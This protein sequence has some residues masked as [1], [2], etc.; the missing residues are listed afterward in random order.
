MIIGIG[1]LLM[2]G[3][4]T[5]ALIPNIPSDPKVFQKDMTRR[6]KNTAEQIRKDFK[7]TT[8]N[9]KVQVD[10]KVTRKRKG[11]SYTFAA[12]TDNEIYGYVN[13]GT[14]PHLITAKNAPFLVFSYPST[15]KTQPNVLKSGKG[16]RGNK[17]ASKKQVKHPGTKARNF[18]KIIAKRFRDRWVSE[19]N[20][21]LRMYMLKNTRPAG[22]P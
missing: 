20:E 5:K 7:K 13:D 21:A 10:F 1:G 11:G 4:K 8:K 2:V 9:W 22:R 18:D 17:W 15:P 14:K 16:K 6:A 3:F 19:A 12:F